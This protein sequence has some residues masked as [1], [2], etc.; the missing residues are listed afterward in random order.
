MSEEYF[1][2]VSITRAEYQRLQRQARDAS[3]L[4]G[5]V[6]ALQRLNQ[7]VERSQRANQ[8]RIDSLTSQLSS[9]TR[10]INSLQTQ[11]SQLRN[12]IAQTVEQQNRQIRDLAVRH[13]QELGQMHRDFSREIGTVR[14]EMQDNTRQIVQAMQ[15]QRADLENQMRNLDRELRA[16][17]RTMQ[18]QIDAIDQTV[19]GMQ[20][21][22]ATLSD[23]ARTYAGAAHSILRELEGHRVDQFAPGRRLPLQAGLDNVESDLSARLSGVGAAA[24]SEAR[25]ILA[26]TL[27]LRQEVLAAE[28]RWEFERQ[29]TLQTI[30]QVQAQLE[31]SRQIRLEDETEELDVDHWS[32]GTLG[33]LQ[34][35]MDSLRR[36]A[37]NRSLSTE[38]IQELQDAAVQISRE[39][40]ET[41]VFAAAAFRASCERYDLV[42]D[43]EREL[44]NGS[45]GNGVLLQLEE[46]AYQGEDPRAGIR[47]RLTN[48]GTGL[49][50]AV[51]LRPEIGPDGRVGNTFTYDVISD[52]AHDAAFADE[53]LG[54]I[55]RVL[56]SRGLECTEPERLPEGD[57]RCNA[58]ETRFDVE[59]WRGETAQVAEPRQPERQAAGQAGQA[60]RTDGGRRS[61]GGR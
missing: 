57:T 58:A 2:R 40:D 54:N 38:Q 30:E 50:M 18:G 35:R 52:G 36:E 49:E 16:E 29:L 5:R 25:Q 45:A 41:T 13:Q 42:A 59:R 53:V 6:D 55:L 1:T 27:A 7:A 26:D 15:R 32:C 43:L 39:I 11:N 61:A 48:P 3:N 51:T 22:N 24:R 20:A 12:Q 47:A 8:Q 21:D 60:G 33:Q 4:A 37:D 19:R 28:Q 23:M 14:R 46:D 10:A 56:R 31:A 9:S 34:V 17:M 44:F